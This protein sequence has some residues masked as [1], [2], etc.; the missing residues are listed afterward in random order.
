MLDKGCDEVLTRLFTIADDINACI[1]L[2]LQGNSQCVLFAAGELF[3][4]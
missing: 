2:F 3:I 4:R 1:L